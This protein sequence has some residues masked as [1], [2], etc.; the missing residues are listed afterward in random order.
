MKHSFRLLCRSLSFVVLLMPLHP[1]PCL[2][3]T[4]TWIDTTTGPNLWSNSAMWSGGTIADGAGFNANFTSNITVNTTVTLDSN[5]NISNLNF[6]DNGTSGS[7]WILNSSGGSILTLGDGTTVGTSTIDT[8]T[9]ANITAILAGANSLTK[10]GAGTLQLGALNTYSGGTIVNGGILDLTNGGTTGAIRGTLAVNAGATVRV[11]IANGLGTSQNVRVTNVNLN[12]GTLDIQ[13]TGS[14]SITASTITMTGGVITGMSGSKFDL[15][16]NN[17]G[18][19]TSVTTLSSATTSVINVTDLGM[20]NNDTT[21][22]TAAGTTPTG[23]DLHISSNIVNRAGT[24]SSAG[25]GTSS[26]IKAGAGTMLLSG[27]NTYTGITTL[28]ANGGILRFATQTSLY[29]NVSANWTAAN[30]IVNTGSTLAFNVGGTGEFTASDITTLLTNINGAVNNNGLRAGSSIGFD[31]TNAAGGVFTLSNVIA[32]TTGT[33]GGTVGLVKLGS[34]TLQLTGVNT[35][36]GTTVV[37]GG[38]LDLAV[39]GG[40]GAIRSA[41]TVNSGAIVRVSVA[42]GLGTTSGTRLSSTILNGGT[43]D[44][45]NTGNNSI[46]ST[47]ITMTGAT[48]T[49]MA[50]SRLDLR[51]IGAGQASVN[52]LASSNTSTISVPT[53]GFVSS[54]APTFTVAAGTTTSGIDLL[55]T[56]VIAGGTSNPLTKAGAGTMR[57]SAANT[58]TGDTN[59]NAGTL[60]LANQNALQSSTV[61]LNG[62]SVIFD[63]SVTGNAFT[64]GGLAGTGN[65]SL[66][67]NAGSPAA[68]VLTVG[69]N[70]ANT[71]Y[72]G[73]LSGAGGLTKQGTGVLTLTGNNTNTGNMNLNAGTLR[74]NSDAAIG[75]NTIFTAN[76]TAS[77]T[78]FAAIDATPITFTKNVN[79]HA[80]TGGIRFG[81]SVGTGDLTFTGN[82]SRTSGNSSR[83]VNVFGSTIVT[84][85]GNLLSPG[86]NATTPFTKSGSGTL[87]IQGTGSATDV[88]YS[89]VN[90]TGGTMAVTRLADLG[91]A[92]S[93]GRAAN[94]TTGAVSIVLDGGTLA[95]IDGGA[96][97]SSTNRMLQIGRTTAGGTGTLLNNATNASETVTFSHAGAIAYGTVDQTRS[98]ILGGSNTGANTLASIVNNNGTGQVSVTKQDAGRWVLSGANTYSGTTTVSGGTLSIASTGRT[99]TG[100]VSVQTGSTI[101]GTGLVQGIS[102][103]AASGSTVH[104]GNGI[105]QADYG[106][107]SFIPNSGSG[108]FDFQSGSTTI[109]GINPGGVGDGDLL[110]FNGLSA[111]TLLFNGNLTVSA[112]GYLPSRE[113]I[114]NLLD[115][116][117]LTTTYFDSRYS[118][119]SYSGLILGNGDDNLGFDLPDISSS[120]F[121]WDISQFVLNGTIGVVAVPEPGR[122]LLLGLGIATL[123][124]RRRRASL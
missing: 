76:G 103:T 42:D 106:T 66:A 87:V 49:G 21:F 30:L 120:G 13:N 93:L 118:A 101:L 10:T 34:G 107:L 99:G 38:T 2:A 46:T 122:A 27:A 26:L 114:F 110:S 43:L 63:S 91:V 84:F 79:M 82:L 8:L 68:V 48:I 50:G 60:N 20:P 105:A 77:G 32:N 115:W 116:T 59:A 73:N 23:V 39:G 47:S 74:V 104:A 11:S 67:N 69:G 119:S 6:S 7:A 14:N 36:T 33:G 61:N 16:Y 29:N 57:L 51:N 44:I 98:L 90:I 75:S 58:F 62:G 54:N 78:V 124:L 81:D 65:L 97:A 19:F 31:T 4:G 24:T 18:S 112:A 22:T 71:T 89:I 95:Y 72:S 55:I 102:F 108:S 41:L 45:Q 80:G 40:A 53:L 12:G 56:S 70:N 9:Q 109:L 37:N 1:A 5:R 117:N 88:G 15:R 28:N 85:N 17:A 113:E 35:Y 123:L 64:F 83:E 86:S 121:G 3:D 100:A 94:A 92:S 52:T 111:G 25:S 96:A